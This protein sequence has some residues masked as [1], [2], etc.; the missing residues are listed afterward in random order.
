MLERWKSGVNCGGTVETIAASPQLDLLPQRSFSQPGGEAAAG[1]TMAHGLEF[2]NHRQI[3]GCP[4]A[5]GVYSCAQSKEKALDTATCRLRAKAQAGWWR[6]S[7]AY[8]FQLRYSTDCSPPIRS[9]SSSHLFDRRSEL[10]WELTESSHPETG[11]SKT[12][13]R[14]ILRRYC[15]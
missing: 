10:K 1:G 8:L 2:S 7:Q 3:L 13:H 5:K 15:L 12:Q 6:T 14:T 11:G 9:S 4:P